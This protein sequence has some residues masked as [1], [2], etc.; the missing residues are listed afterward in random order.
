M[1]GALGGG[2]GAQQK[3][4]GNSISDVIINMQN[5]T[6]IQNIIPSCLIKLGTQCIK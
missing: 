5:K 3:I 2:E 4:P 1:L 6:K